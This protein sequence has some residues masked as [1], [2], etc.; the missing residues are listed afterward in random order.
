MAERDYTQDLNQFFYRARPHEYFHHRLFNL[1]LL[2]TK[3]EEIA[4]VA[5]DGLNYG[6]VTVEPALSYDGQREPSPLWAFATCESQVLIHHIAEVLLRLFLA[7]R[8]D[9]PC[10]ALELAYLRL[11]K[12]FKTALRG[13]LDEEERPRRNALMEVFW[14][15]SDVAHLAREQPEPDWESGAVAIERLLVH[16]AQRLLTEAPLY[17]AAKHGLA[18]AT[19]R[20]ALTIDIDGVDLGMSTAGLNV[21]YLE[22]VQRD[23]DGDRW[24]HTTRWIDEKTDIAVCYLWTHL[25]DSLWSVASNRYLG[26][27]GYTIYCVPD[28]AVKRLLEERQRPLTAMGRTFV[29]K[30]PVKSGPS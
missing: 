29:F 23:E 3:E 15:R 20:S 6:L 17:N 21:E 9:P 18:I 8:G 11:P 19:G 24:R 4:K 5:A 1:I 22:R 2:L 14:G 7:H 13:F 25:I 27:E 26:V 30:R 10:P 28:D 16:G 12:E